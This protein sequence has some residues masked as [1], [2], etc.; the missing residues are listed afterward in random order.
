MV[1]TRASNK[2][3]WHGSVAS[4]QWPVTACHQWLLCFNFIARCQKIR[5]DVRASNVVFCFDP[6]HSWL[7]S[8]FGIQSARVVIVSTD[9]HTHTRAHICVRLWNARVTFNFRDFCLA[10]SRRTTAVSGY[11][12]V[13]TFTRRANKTTKESLMQH[14]GCDGS[15]NRNSFWHDVGM[16]LCLCCETLS[17]EL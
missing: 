13:C 9:T 12:F 15:T 6:F 3:Q 11:D 5:S 17:S 10:V 4:T 2:A 16:M 8:P 1:I 7:S 14:N